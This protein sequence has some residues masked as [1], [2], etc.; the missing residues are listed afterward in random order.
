MVSNW[1]MASSQ[2]ESSRSQAH[3]DL[4][5]PSSV[6]PFADMESPFVEDFLLFD[7]ADSFGSAPWTSVGLGAQHHDFDGGAFDAFTR[8]NA[9]FPSDDYSSPAPVQA[10]NYIDDR[11]G[12][13]GR[14]LSP[15]LDSTRGTLVWSQNAAETPGSHIVAS[16]LHENDILTSLPLVH[17]QVPDVLNTLQSASGSP[18]C[19]RNQTTRLPV[20]QVQTQASIPYP[21]SE[22]PKHRDT[23]SKISHQGAQPD[24]AA[25][26]LVF[27]NTFAQDSIDH[28][29]GHGSWKGTSGESVMTPGALTQRAAS[30]I[31][32]QMQNSGDD[33]AINTIVPSMDLVQMRGAPAPSLSST[34]PI[35]GGPTLTDS[36]NP[37]VPEVLSFNS[38]S[39]AR[40]YRQ[41]R[42]P[43]NIANDDVHEVKANSEGWVR[44]GMAALLRTDYLAPPNYKK[45]GKAV[46]REE[47]AKWI[48]WQDDQVAKMRQILEKEDVVRDAEALAWDLLEKVINVHELGY[49]P[50]STQRHGPDKES[51][52]AKR[53]QDAIDIIHD[54]TIVRTGMFL[55]PKRLEDFVRN[56]IA[57]VDSKKTNLWVNDKKAERERIRKAQEA[58]EKAQKE[59]AH[60]PVQTTSNEQQAVDDQQQD[61]RDSESVTGEQAVVTSRKRKTVVR[62]VDFEDT[63]PAKKPKGKKDSGPHKNE[64]IFKAGITEADLE[65]GHAFSD[66]LLHK[67][68]KTRNG[69]FLVLIA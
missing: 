32:G 26:H 20:T 18:H 50:S 30:I 43:L 33:P 49:F 44:K 2:S 67:Q 41:R 23:R 1:T 21:P 22:P 51:K 48:R 27:V 42:V 17:Y 7:P 25:S 29:N 6:T 47:K 61:A 65:A 35:D 52:C 16:S 11:N 34:E 55:S 15:P 24:A 28:F 59:A 36:N 66:R 10:S 63:R 14:H 57:F 60:S 56:P 38:I 39:D 8:D 19:I 46:T 31:D 13:P 45:N 69:L 40:A 54:Y 58:R 12:N 53:L 9:P 64:A 4:D 62:T 68:D 5:L 37:T 3:V